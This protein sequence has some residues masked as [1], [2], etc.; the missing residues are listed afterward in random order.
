M[1]KVETF[2]GS[3]GGYLVVVT[4]GRDIYDVF[5]DEHMLGNSRVA[6]CSREL[7]QEP[8]R[9]WIKERFDP[10]DVTLHIGIDW[11]ETER[12][13]GNRRGW[14]PYYVEAPMTE[15]PYIDK[16]QMLDMLRAEGIA[17]PR[18][19][20]MGFS[21]ANCGGFCVRMGH[22]QATHLLTVMPDRYA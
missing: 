3:S 5:D 9:R 18:L 15:P 8:A 12:I 16:D 7:K 20:G 11:T 2:R 19:Y 6:P 14:T 4:E 1:D 17:P 10:E 22:K 21:H 13:E